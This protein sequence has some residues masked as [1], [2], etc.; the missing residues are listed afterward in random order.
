M[1]LELSLVLFPVHSSAPVIIE[2]EHYEMRLG[3]ND[4]FPCRHH[5]EEP[6][7]LAALWDRI[8]I[9]DISAVLLI[10]VTNV[11]VVL[12]QQ[13]LVLGNLLKNSRLS[14]GLQFVVSELFGF[15]RY[16]LESL[17]V[18]L[19]RDEIDPRTMAGLGVNSLFRWSVIVFS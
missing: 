13:L 15:D 3:V 11:S 19:H 2:T 9:Q 12:F 18:L 17:A 4:D 7:T 8:R 1:F 16:E 6:S 5:F 14:A 10:G